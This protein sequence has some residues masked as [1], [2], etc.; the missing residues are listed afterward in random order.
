M[1]DYV[2]VYHHQQEGPSY[3]FALVI[4]FFSTITHS[5][6]DSLVNF[7]HKFTIK[8]NMWFFTRLV[9][10]EPMFRMKFEFR[11]NF[12]TL[13][14]LL[15]VFIYHLGHIERKEQKNRPSLFIVNGSKSDSGLRISICIRNVWVEL[16]AF[17]SWMSRS[18]LNNLYSFI[19]RR[20]FVYQ[21]QMYR[22]SNYSLGEYWI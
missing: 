7:I 20:I 19:I 16:L 18:T 13:L 9:F 1:H 2:L 21:M 12:L 6:D 15:L 11:I 8:R 10:D 22:L 14:L 4:S 3:F 17:G 5:S